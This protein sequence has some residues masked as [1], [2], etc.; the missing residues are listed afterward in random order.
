MQSFCAVYFDFD[1]M[2]EQDFS[3]FNFVHT[4]PDQHRHKWVEMALYQQVIFVYRMEFD[5]TKWGVGL[6]WWV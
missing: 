2:C 5:K 3:G 1:G 6:G 4:D